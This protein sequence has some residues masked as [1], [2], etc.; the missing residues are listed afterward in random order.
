M[1]YEISTI[2]Q[3][4]DLTPRQQK[5]FIADLYGWLKVQNMAKSLHEAGLPISG[6]TGTMIW[7]DD[8]RP[9]EI[10]ELRIKFT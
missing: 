9:G 8:G 4:C 2:Q 3:I 6:D 7:N 5:D 10:S 1:Q